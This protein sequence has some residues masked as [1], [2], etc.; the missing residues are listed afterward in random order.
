M[1]INKDILIEVSDV[2]LDA[3]RTTIHGVSL[4]TKQNV[5]TTLINAPIVNKQDNERL[6]VTLNDVTEEYEK[7][8]MCFITCAGI[9]LIPQV[10]LRAQAIVDKRAHHIPTQISNQGVSP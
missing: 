1:K 4:L 6:L 9:E 8:G 7:D 5:Q 10:P 3:G 2:V